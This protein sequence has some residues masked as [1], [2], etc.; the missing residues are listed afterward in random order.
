MTKPPPTQTDATRL[1]P[2]REL[3]RLGLDDLLQR[4]GSTPEGLGTSL[5]SERLARTGPNEVARRKPQPWWRQ[6]LL[7]FHSPFNYLLL[8]LGAVSYVSG[9]RFSAVMIAVMILLS[10][11]LR[12]LQERRSSRAAERLQAMVSNQ[13]CVFRDGTPREVSLAEIVPGDVVQLSAGDLVPADIRLLESKNLHLNQSALTGEAF[14]VEKSAGAQPMPSEE[15]V[16]YGNLCFMGTSVLSGTGRAVVLATGDQTYF[17]NLATKVVAEEPPTAFETGL[18]ALSWLLIRFI[19][20]MVFIILLINGFTKGDWLVAFLFALSVGVGLTPELLPMVVT[21]NLSRGALTLSARKV[22]V[23]RLSSIQNLG[24]MDILCTDKT[25]TL[26]RNEVILYQHLDLHGRESLT[27]LKAAYLNSHFQTGLKNLLDEAILKHAVEDDGLQVEPDYHK[28]DEIPFDFERRRLSVILRRGET[29]TLF[30]KGAVEETMAVCT[31]F[32]DKGKDFPMTP[33]MARLAQQEVE[34]L[35]EDGFRVVAIATRSLPVEEKRYTLDDENDLTLLGFIAFLDPPKEST[36][37]AVRSLSQLG[38]ELKILT[39]DSP[40][41]TQKICRT[42]NLPVHGMLTGPEIDALNDEALAAR[43]EQTTLFAKLTPDHK[44][45]IIRALRQNH[46][47]GFLGDG[48]NDSP[49]LKAADIG[50]SVNNAVDIAK[51]SADMILLEQNLLVLRDG[52]VEGRKVFGNLVKYIRMTTSSNFGNVLSM[53]GA[54]FI[55]PFLPMKPIHILTQNLLYDFSQTAIPFDRV[56]EDF[57]KAPHPWKISNIERFMLV[58]GPVSSLFDYA[59][60]AIMWFVFGANTPAKQSLF[61]A[62]WFIEGLLSQVFIVHMIRTRQIPFLQSWP[63]PQLLLTSVIIMSIGIA[64]PYSPLAIPMGF[65]APPPAYF[66]WLLAILVAYFL[67]TQLVK[68]WFIT[69]Y[70]YD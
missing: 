41:V 11:G 53:L 56:D 47:V 12:F 5:A 13:V 54:S 67:L 39:G 24:A 18:N 21:T 40:L 51:E 30:C 35:N 37:E 31:R 7:T 48:I 6:L 45:R 55:L 68:R 50:L 36:A 34:R 23:K 65:E 25:G 64:L 42:V 43:A 9:N 52:V 17:G 32:H 62:G 10:V 14:P 16:D 38:I 60:F 22:I 59:L 70:G 69:K 3:A 2:L 33:Q 63:A 15:P 8:L 46:V 26:T 29:Q 58:F 61:Q 19:L 1:N 28:V 66:G 4:L 20:S 49:A 57:L 44:Q 27:V